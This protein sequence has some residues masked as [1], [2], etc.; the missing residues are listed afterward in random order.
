VAGLAGRLAVELELRGGIVSPRER[1]RPVYGI[2]LPA[3]TRRL[4]GL[5]VSHRRSTLRHPCGE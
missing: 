4:V 2:A 3:V 1:R 5:K